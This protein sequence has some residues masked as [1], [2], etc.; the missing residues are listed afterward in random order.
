M[1]RKPSSPTFPTDTQ[2]PIVVEWPHRLFSGVTSRD[3]RQ[4]LNGVTIANGH[5]YASNGRILVKVPA[6][7]ELLGVVAI[8]PNT[9]IEAIEADVLAGDQYVDSDGDLVTTTRGWAIAAVR[10]HEKTVSYLKADGTTISAEYIFGSPPDFDKAIPENIGDRVTIGL[11]AEY[12]LALGACLHGRK[13]DLPG[14]VYVTFNRGNLSAAQLVS[15]S[16]GD[17]LRTDA[18]AVIMPLSPAK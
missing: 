4:V 6:P 5:F 7:P 12:L 15:I 16:S 10:L 14:R 11:D 13:N 18:T 3:S 2:F 9:I 17:E 8:I 1:D